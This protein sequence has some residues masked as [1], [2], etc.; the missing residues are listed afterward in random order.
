M[1]DDN[2][3][4]YTVGAGA[5]GAGIQK[6]GTLVEPGVIPAEDLKEMEAFE[7]GIQ[8]TC[9]VM[10]QNLQRYF[11]S[12]LKIVTPLTEQKILGRL[13]GLVLAFDLGEPERRA[14][15][16]E[17]HEVKLDRGRIR[18]VVRH[19]VYKSVGHGLAR[20]GRG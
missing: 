1:E 11:D 4:G 13:E 5:V 2:A 18:A 16:K 15:L 3:E 10:V 20:A 7:A 19:L 12:F 14:F 17:A 8:G 9:E 6:L